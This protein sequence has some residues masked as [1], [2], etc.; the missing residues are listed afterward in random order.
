MKVGF[1]VTWMNRENAAG[2][3]FQYALRLIS[4]LAEYTETEVIAVVGPER[5]GIFDN[6]KNRPNFHAV[7]CDSFQS[8]SDIVNS[9]R[10]DVVHTPLQRHLNY[11]LAVPMITTL[12]DLQQFHY[13]EFFSDEEI[14]HRN[15]YYRKTAEFSEQVIVSYGHVKE[16]I[17]N[18]YGIPAEKIQVCPVGMSQ[19][20][21]VN[22][23][24]YPEIR[25]K[26]RISG[27]Y[28]FYSANTWRHKN[29]IRLVRALRLLHD[30]YG[31]RLSLVCT[32]YKYDDYYLEIQKVVED[33][34]LGEFVNF[35]DY[36]PEEDLRLLLS[37]AALVV[38]PTLYEAG[39]FPLMEA[40]AYQVP[41]ICSN[42]T[43]LPE[44]IGDRRF[45][46]APTNV[47]EIAEKIASML[48]SE[49][50][51]EENRENSQKRVRDAAWRLVIPRFLDVYAKAV[52]SFKDKR[53]LIFYKE[54]LTN[55]DFFVNEEIKNV[56]KKFEEC[57]ADREA[58]LQVIEKQGKEFAARLTE[59]EADRAAR[60]D[61]IE[62]QGKEFS[63]KIKE[64]RDVLET[65]E[66]EIKEIK[67]STS[68]KITAPLRWISGKI[69]SRGRS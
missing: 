34:R 6:I 14:R 64:M 3:V 2:G 22:K 27:P 18:F 54:W 53:S 9:H 63:Q 28:L 51:M 36:V 65:R 48:G 38:I 23:A 10:I 29:H 25:S 61:V 58:R 11:T 46:F 42:V 57:E 47:E 69:A 40:M 15:L 8:L 20:K 68:W 41:V 49:A 66:A 56:T 1:D 67:L 19:P 62:R 55:Y 21:P 7:V 59:C 31:F 45:V 12:H 13:P 5:A 44:T 33:L 37:N 26:Y 17:I 24:R 35:T 32:G 50:L 30:K 52:E 43:S 39:S 16:D 60:L 4:A